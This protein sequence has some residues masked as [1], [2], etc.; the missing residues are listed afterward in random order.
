MLV[1][2]AFSLSNGWYTEEQYLVN[3]INELE[4]RF[5]W[6][7]CTFSGKYLQRRWTR[8]CHSNDIWQ[9]DKGCRKASHIY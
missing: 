5:F 4:F 8:Q 3:A 2:L 9:L 7:P 6:T 1:L